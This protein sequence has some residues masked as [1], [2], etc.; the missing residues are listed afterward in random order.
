MA[1]FD[2]QPNGALTN[3]REFV[4]FPGGGG[5][6]ITIDSEGRIYVTGATGLQVAGPDGKY[7]GLIPR[8]RE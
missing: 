5:D 6:G 7:L 3:Q 2:V 4:A 8:H 1:A